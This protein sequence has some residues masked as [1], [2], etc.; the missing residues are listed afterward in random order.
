LE[1]A[2]RDALRRWAR[3]SDAE[4]DQAARE[5]LSLF[6][7]LGSDTKLAAGTREQLRT[8]VRGRLM[9]LSEQITK[10][11]ARENRQAKGPKTLETPEGKG[12]G[13]AQFGRQGFGGMGGP[14]MMRPGMMGPGMAGGMGGWGGGG[15]AELDN[16]QA[17][18]DLIQK[19]IA[20]STWDV[21]GGPGSIYYWQP[22]R[23][24]IVRQTGEV[25]EQ[26]NDALRQLERAGR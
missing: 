16:G 20:P 6:D 14:G 26:V 23:A 17:L 11:V 7:S 13:L 19:T 25:H 9:Q 3:P 10:R 5:F 18:V 1:R 8:K 12:Q 15:S 2:V 24:L 4:A 21:N 22:H